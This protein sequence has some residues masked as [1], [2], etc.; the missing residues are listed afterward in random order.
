MKKIEASEQCV[1]QTSST[2][3]R[4]NLCNGFRV[5]VCVCVETES[6]NLV[7]TSQICK[8]S[9][10]RGKLQTENTASRY[11]KS[12]LSISVHMCV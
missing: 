4:E 2:K 7:E 8:C 12:T 6:T 5:R 9:S 10:N 11:I 1:A 3:F